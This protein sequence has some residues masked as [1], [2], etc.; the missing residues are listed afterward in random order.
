MLGTQIQFGWLVASSGW[1][2]I[3]ML[4][5]PSASQ[6]RHHLQHSKGSVAV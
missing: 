3:H 4:H 6:E 1:H 5:K 2:A